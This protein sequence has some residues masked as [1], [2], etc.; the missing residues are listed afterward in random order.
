MSGKREGSSGHTVLQWPGLTLRLYQATH[1][2]AMKAAQ[3]GLHRAAVEPG[4]AYDK[5]AWM[6]VPRADWQ[7]MARGS[8]A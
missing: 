1:T 2:H 5:K 6:A 4:K 8:M 7:E 3:S